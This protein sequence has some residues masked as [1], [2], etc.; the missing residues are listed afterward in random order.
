M[1]LKILAGRIKC[2]SFT[3]HSK[4]FQR[5]IKSNLQ[6]N[7]IEFFFIFQRRRMTLLY[8]GSSMNKTLIF[9]RLTTWPLCDYTSFKTKWENI[10]YINIKWIT[11]NFPQGDIFIL[12]V[13]F[14]SGLNYGLNFKWS[15]CVLSNSLFHAHGLQSIY[16]HFVFLQSNPGIF[17]SVAKG[18]I[19][20]Y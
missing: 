3:R 8:W 4:L 17:F 10:I 7:T 2:L 14:I 9:F 18:I 6:N 19:T 20:V 12:A 15:Q 11:D 16:Q 13:T 5:K 1:I